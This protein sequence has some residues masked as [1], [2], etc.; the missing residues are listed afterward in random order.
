M[1]AKHHPNRRRWH[2]AALDDW[3]VQ[4]QS[5]AL[6]VHTD[7]VHCLCVVYVGVSGCVQATRSQQQQQQVCESGKR[8]SVSKSIETLDL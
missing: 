1:P 4:R 7:C 3:I 5:D 2:L 6:C 8:Q